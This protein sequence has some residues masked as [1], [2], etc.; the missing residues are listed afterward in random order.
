MSL[1]GCGGG[2][3]GAPSV[4]SSATSTGATA[5]LQWNPVQ[6]G[7]GDPPIFGYY[8][9]YGKSSAGQPGNC[10][11]GDA[12]F[13]SSPT[14]TITNLEHGTRYYFAVTAYNGQE[15]PCSSEVSADV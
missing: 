15:S 3:N 14:V 4:S 12:L 8:V 2:E 6:P 5:N 1:S 10:P 7:P 11:N 9:H 13:S